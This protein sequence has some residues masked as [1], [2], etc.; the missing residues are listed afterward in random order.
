MIKGLAIGDLT[1]D[2]SNATRIREFY[3]NLTGWERTVA[4]NC[5]ALKADIGMSILFVETDIPY[6]P[7]VWPE[8]MVDSRNKCTLP[9]FVV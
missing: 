2:C 4:Y 7:P 8:E 9:Y 3:A 6:V 5:L 1:I